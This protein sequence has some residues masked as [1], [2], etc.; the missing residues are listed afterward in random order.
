MREMLCADRVKMFTEMTV[1]YTHAVF[2]HITCKMASSENKLRGEQKRGIRTVLKR[3]YFCI[4]SILYHSGL[5][6]YSVHV[7][8][9]SF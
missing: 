1:L 3:N 8:V 4:T 5:P 2:Q 6:L 7:Q 9:K